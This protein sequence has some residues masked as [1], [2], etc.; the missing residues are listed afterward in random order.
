MFEIKQPKI[1]I[2]QKD[3]NTKLSKKFGFRIRKPYETINHMEN[4][5]EV[6]NKFKVKINEPIPA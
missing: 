4:L 3:I 5:I 2:K 6:Q 1:V